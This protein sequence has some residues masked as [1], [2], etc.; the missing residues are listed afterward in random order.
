MQ[1][2]PV[3]RDSESILFLTSNRHSIHSFCLLR[4]LNT[5]T[6]HRDHSTYVEGNVTTIGGEIRITL[7]LFY[8]K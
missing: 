1:Y 4:M 8:P 6:E 7:S 5:P 2:P 3:R